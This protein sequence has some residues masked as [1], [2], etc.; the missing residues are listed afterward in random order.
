MQMRITALAHCFARRKRCCMD[1]ILSTVLLDSEHTKPQPYAT[2]APMTY[3]GARSRPIESETKRFFSVSKIRLDAA[4][5]A[6]HVL[7]SEVAS[8]SNMDVG[9]HMVV[10][11]GDVVDAIHE[12]SV[13]SVVFPP[14]HTHLPDQTLEVI[15]R[16]DGSETIAMAKRPGIAASLLATLNDIATLGDHLQPKKQKSTFTSRRRSQVVYAVSKVGLDADGRVTDVLWGRVDTAHNT[17][18]APEVVAP[19]AQAVA[20]LQAG[21]QVFAL[22]PSA[23]GHLPEGQ[24]TTVEYDD[25][26]QTI[27]LAGPALP[28][29]AIHDMD[30]LSS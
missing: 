3:Q 24:F 14:P 18:A 25:G 1:W 28:D 20:A 7:W 11:V 13:V 8:R 26:R 21:D 19:V 29:R 15:E 5:W 16:A 30:R 2:M 10:P 9:N 17:W 27:V 22:F 23:N 4:G 6:T 12:G